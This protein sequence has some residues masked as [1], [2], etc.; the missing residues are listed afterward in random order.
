MDNTYE[1]KLMIVALVLILCAIAL[2]YIYK[3]TVRRR[4][5]S[6]QST[7]AFSNR[8]PSIELNNYSYREPESGPFSSSTNQITSLPLYT[9]TPDP[10]QDAGYYKQDG[11]F[12]S[13]QDINKNQGKEQSSVTVSY[14]EQSQQLSEPP[15]F[16]PPAYNQADYHPPRTPPPSFHF[17][18]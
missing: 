15:P 12:V 13:S 10:I 3:V 11:T 9:E 18:F 2:F 1:G 4:L 5:R 7:T 8:V 17:R 16:E 14:T 6:L